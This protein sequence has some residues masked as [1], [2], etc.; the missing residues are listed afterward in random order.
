MTDGVVMAHGIGTVEDLP[1][2]RSLTIAGAAVAVL[3]SFV[4][5]AYAW[6][7]PRF[8][9]APA[10]PAPGWLAALIDHPLRRGACQ[11]FGMLVFSFALMCAA[12]GNDSLNNP[13]FGMLYV[14]AWVAPVPLSLIF[15]PFWRA[16]SPMRTIHGALVR[17][18]GVAPGEGLFAYPSRL[19]YWPAA[20]GLFAFVWM[21]LVYPDNTEL[22]PLRLWFTIYVAAMLMGSAMFG[23]R[24]LAH[25][26]PF[27][28]Y[29][30]LVAK[31]SPWG[32][33]GSGRLVMRSPLANLHTLEPKPG[34]LAVVG[35]LLGSTAFDSFTSTSYWADLV[36]ASTISATLLANGILIAFCAGVPGLIAIG[37]M[38]GSVPTE[39]R[40]SRIDLPGQFAPS[41]VP[42]IVGYIFAH[43]FT[44]LVHAG[45]DTLIKM[46]DPFET[47][48][49]WFG[50]ADRRIGYWLQFH[51]TLVASLKVA[52][53]V[54]G[55]VVAVVAAHD[56]ALTVLSKS[57]RILGQLALLVVMV[58]FTGSGLFLLF[59][60]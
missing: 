32:R 14:F 39:S 28:V 6:R 46:S 48:A 59:S 9:S 20:L 58:F 37:A 49:N 30:S 47:G 8:G 1:L 51:P 44:F 23:D 12:F 4:V 7:A 19:G 52:G 11:A 57:H 5:L 10:R 13:F 24:F 34:L 36:G 55:H 45:Q 21:E 2:P 17:A 35:V 25:A 43:Y 15:G 27:E 33:D 50:T 16:V 53:V 3:L 41:I 22:G 56:R 29:S 42:I 40:G 54:I 38:L 18:V 31:L 26:D 60:S